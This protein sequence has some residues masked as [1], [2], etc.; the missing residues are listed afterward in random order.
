MAKA[1]VLLVDDEQDFTATLS[2]R[3]ESRGMSVDVASSGPEAIEKARARTYDAL[4]LDLAMPGMDGIETLK[5]LL[6]ENPDLQVILLTG[7]ATVRKGVEAMASGAMEVLEKPADINL[8]LAQIEKAHANR[9]HLAEKRVEETIT[10]ILRK[11]G[12]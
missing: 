7:R 5:R 4:V 2:E 1:T 6:A 10:D 11:K 3:L 8:L 9:V 12:W